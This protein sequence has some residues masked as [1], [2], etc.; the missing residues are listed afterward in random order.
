M[1]DEGRTPINF[2]SWGHRSRSCHALRCIVHFVTLGFRSLQPE[3]AHAN[4]IIHDILRANT[5]LEKGLLEK[6]WLSFP[7]VYNFP[8]K[9]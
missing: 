2:G 5:V 6:I 3:L 1:D 4:E 8:C 9:L 7:V